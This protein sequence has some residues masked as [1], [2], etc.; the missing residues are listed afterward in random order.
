M[1][2]PWPVGSATGVGSLPGTDPAEAVREVFGELPEL[3]HLPELPGRGP[4]ADLIGRS[5][6]LLTDLHV[7]LQPAGWRF[8]ASAGLDERRAAGL[9]ARDLDAL[10]EHASAYEGPLKLQAAGPWTLAAGVELP[11]GNRA[12][13]DPGAVRDITAALAEGLTVHLADVRTRVP[14]ATLLL[15]LDEPAL[16]AVLTG[17]VPTA[18]GFATLRSVDEVVATAALGTV[19]DALGAAGAV[20]VVHCCAADPP[21]ELLTSAGAAALSLDATLLSERADDALGMAIEA[22]V[23]LLLGVVAA[24]PSTDAELSHP[25]RTVEPVREI[26][27]RLGFAADRLA[28]VVAVTPTCGLAGATPAYARAAMTLC[29]SAARLLAE[30]G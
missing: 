15:Q 20:P 21:I 23:G 3:P 13:S 27:R 11:R 4:G 18:S 2:V 7:D 16:P 6:V 17:R 29:R 14:G 12:L 10:E 1:S 5:A 19:I 28:A 30:D 24:D 22:G 25:S 8:V 9:L 26:W